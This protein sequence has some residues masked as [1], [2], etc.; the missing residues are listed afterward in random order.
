MAQTFNPE[1][2]EKI[3][4]SLTY[5]RVWIVYF[6]FPIIILL[7]DIAINYIQAIYFPTPIDIIIYNEKKY[8]EQKKH[9]I[10][11]EINDIVDPFTPTNKKL[12]NEEEEKN[13]IILLSKNTPNINE[14]DFKSDD[15]SPDVVKVGSSRIEFKVISNNSDD[16]D[17]LK[18]IGINDMEVK[19]NSMYGDSL[20]LSS[21][22]KKK[23]I[24]NKY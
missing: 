19:R 9:K 6:I 21:K 5:F 14:H 17:A 3:F 13:Q 18:K 2:I 12:K 16:E 20:I 15:Q 23:E 11:N 4:V 10:Q 8:L 1:I 7:P 24:S 22:I